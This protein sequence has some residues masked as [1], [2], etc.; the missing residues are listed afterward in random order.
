MDP[1]GFLRFM[2]FLQ[3]LP[4]GLCFLFQPAGPCLQLIFIQHH[5]GRRIDGDKVQLFHGPL[6]LQIKGTDG[7]H[8]IIPQF[9]TQ[10]HFLCQ[11][12]N[13]DNPAADGK[14]SHAVH[15]GHPLI[16]H[17]GQPLSP[18]IK[19]NDLPACDGN[20]LLLQILQGKKVVHQAVHGGDHHSAL[21][22]HQVPEHGN[23]LPCHKVSMDVRTV[24]QQVFGRIE[25]Y[26]VCKVPEII[27]YFL[28]PGVIIGHHQ[29]PRKC[30][31]LPQLIHQMDL[32]G[33]QRTRCLKRPLPLIQGLD[34]IVIFL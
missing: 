24:K 14:L 30:R 32:L 11:R 34:Q 17:G 25:P 27:V 29:L 18:H 2:L 31:P 5:L 22:L 26:L 20:G 16:P 15:L 12:E 3:G 8:F 1:V 9:D 10:R 13:I 19:V 28:G 23:P 21:I 33:V 4:I 6:A 7:I